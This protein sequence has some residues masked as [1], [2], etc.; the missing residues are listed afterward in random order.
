MASVIARTFLVD[1]TPPIGGYMCGGL[2]TEPAIG[3][4]SR[5]SLRGLILDQDNRRYILASIEYTYLVGRSYARMI[6]MLSTAGQ[7]SPDCV[8]LHAVHSHDAPLIN[9]EAHAYVEKTVTD[10]HNEAYFSDVLKRTGEAIDKELKE[11]GTEV[12]GTCFASAAVQKFASSRRILDEN[13]Q[14]QVRWSVC[15]DPVVRNAPEGVIDP[16]LDQ[17]VFYDTAG[18]PFTCLSFYACHPQVSNG[19]RLWS[20]DTVGV[21]LELFEQTYPHVFPIYFT[22][23]AGDITAGK[24]TTLNRPRNRL[25]FG[26]RLFDGMAAA[27]DK[28]RPEPLHRIDWC[29][30]QFD[31]PLCETQ[32]EIEHYRAILDDSEATS[33]VKYKAAIKYH[34]LKEQMNTYPYRLSRLSLN[35]KHIL[36]LP[37]EMCI[38]YQLFAKA[39]CRGE[40]AVAAYGDSFLN[41]VA[42]DEAFDQGGYEV[43]PAWTEVGKGNE[44][45]IREAIKQI[46]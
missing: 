10:V 19:R 17:I 9:E 45:R 16:L 22:G 46:L 6:D 38:P 30:R 5:L 7:T 41:Y 26:L 44:G 35:D 39:Q 4:E 31:M 20:G 43:N 24:Y 14:C 40:L 27:F 42:T 1:V 23:C 3:V 15:R 36:F 21:A 12:A 34:K 28:S 11:E 18:E 2:Q 33:N 8:T 29:D 32:Y 13:D 37:A 25:L